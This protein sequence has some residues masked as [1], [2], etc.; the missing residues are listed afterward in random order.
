MAE[1]A[2]IGIVRPV[3]DKLFQLLFEEAKLFN[4]DVHREVRSLT[5][6]LEIIQCFLKEAEEKRETSEANDGVKTWVKQVREE[7]YHIEDVMD[8][9]LLHV[10]QHRRKPQNGFVGFVHKISYLIKVQRPRYDM[11]SEVQNIKA[12]LI[13]IKNRGEIYGFNSLELQSRS[14]ATNTERNDPRLGSLFIEEAELVRIG[15]TQDEMMRWMIQGASVR[16]VVTLVGAGGI[17][18]TTLARKVYDD[19]VVRGHFDCRAWINVSQSYNTEKLLWI[20][21]KQLFAAGEFTSGDLD[22]TTEDLISSLRQY[23]KTRRYVVIFDDVWQIDLWRIIKHALPSNHQG[24]RIIVT[25]R[26][27]T[28]A[29]FCK[30]TSSD[31]IQKLQPWSLEN[32]WE[33]FCKKAF[34]AEFGG[35]CPQE[36]EQLSLKIVRKCEGLPLVIAAVAGLLSTK[37][38]VV[39]EWQ[40]LSDCLRSEFETNPCLSPYSKILFLSYKDLSYQLKSCFLYFGM[41]PK[42]YSVS[43]SK[44]IGKWITEGFIEEKRD[45]T[46]EQVAEEYLIELVDR[47]LVQSRQGPYG[48]RYCQIHDLMHDI[49]LSKA[50][51]LGFCQ[52]L[53]ENNSKIIGKTRRLSI[54]GN[55]EN[56]LGTVKDSGVRS[57]LFYEVDKLTNSVLVTMFEKF[58]LLK[59]LDFTKVHLDYLPKELGNL[60]HLTYLSLR[61][62]KVKKLPK[63]IGKLENLRILDIRNTLVHKLPKEINK[64]RHLRHLLANS[65]DNA[66]GYPLNDVRGVR[67][68]EGIGNLEDLQTLVTVEVNPDRIGI[69][70]EL[71]KLKQLRSLAISNLTLEF[72]N[73][74]GAAIEK[75]NHLESLVLQSLNHDEVLDLQSI[76]TP[77]QL[78]HLVVI[79]RL[80][81]LPDWISR[82]ENL[83]L[84]GLSFSMLTDD[85]LKS[86][87][88][89]SNLEHLLLYKAY[90]AEQLHFEVSGFPKLRRLVLRELEGLEVVKIEKGALPLLEEFEIGPSPLMK[91]VPS[92]IQHL[93]NLRSLKF[94]EMPKQF[95]VGIQPIEGPD[96]LKVKHVPSVRFSYRVEGKRNLVYKLGEPDLLEHLE[97]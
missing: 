54:R 91:E 83:R 61:N 80:R 65:R 11:A 52:I 37:K 47:N 90:T 85:L 66:I 88:S 5:D 96:D 51:E 1:S 93:Q 73:I 24:S 15:S 82:L 49:I 3:I 18:K 10:A 75:M 53:D 70:K 95:V 6:E 41:Y 4:K 31:L 58:K 30:E 81:K 14:K 78:R 48:G 8:L 64:L 55:R 57:I 22:T 67:I 43:Q 16:S 69:L 60:F 40:K 86:L 25:T 45:R 56:F 72:G 84:L 28:I 46:V 38:K 23:L 97:Q 32:S 62:T 71:E 94:Y 34:Q 39:S 79:S 76:S 29:A 19:E 50:T 68:H 13:E 74:V 21:S 33:L 7:A 17:G 42:N 26:N 12:S 92:D 63:S 44:L 59:V 77:H 87:H 36:L 89:L 35:H 2:V 27:D 20:M 9:Y